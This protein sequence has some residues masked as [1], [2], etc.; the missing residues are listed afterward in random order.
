MVNTRLS[1]ITA[2][3]GPASSRRDWAVAGAALALGLFSF[4]LIFRPEIAAAIHVW[5]NSDA[6]SHCF[7]V[8]PVAAYLAWD[9]RQAVA[10]TALRP[11]PWIALLAFPVA[12]AWFVADRLGI[13]EGRQLVSMTL[14]QIMVAS[15]LGLRTWR[16]LAAPLLYLFFLVPFGEFVVAPLQG[17]AVHFTTAGLDLLG[18][19]NFS[20]GVTIEIP[21]GTFVVHEACSGLRFLVA[22]AAFGVLYACM[23]FT[24][25]LRRVLFI[26]LSLAV[27]IIGN[28]FRVVGIIL[29]AH[30]IGN[31]LAVETS[32]VLWGWLFYLM[33]GSV[34][35]LIGLV[36]RQE[37]RSPVRS[38]PATSGRTTGASVIALTLMI[39]LATMPRVAANYLDQL[40]ADTAVAAQIEMPE[41]PGCMRVLRPSAPPIAS[42]REGLSLGSS[43]S[44]AYQCDDNLFVLTLTR[45]PSRIG[46][47][48]LFSSLRATMVPPAW[49]IILQT[50]DFRA[51]DGPDALVWRVTE[52]TTDDGRYAAVATA[53]WIDGRPTGAGMAARFNQAL[54]TVRRSAVSPVLAVVT[55]FGGNRPNDTRRAID[56]FLPRTAR[57][58]ELVSKSLSA[59]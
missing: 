6:Y 28:C 38:N 19:T 18:I 29:I 48:P 45:Y 9:R 58:S 39:L 57:L 14:F 37:R 16:A 24:S 10:A 20:D 49:D 47:R 7:L 11:T 25:P 27:A 23:M 33:I 8:L 56:A 55:Y 34:L 41:L 59:P 2:V 3:T 5:I 13:M 50:G 36:F 15:L 30:F 21:E 54:N 22:S 32:H 51:W 52:A 4:G 53:L 35:I 26:A 17:L 42:A 44:S 40:G 46:V 43:R 1:P 31:A 12:A